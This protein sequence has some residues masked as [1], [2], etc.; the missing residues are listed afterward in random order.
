MQCPRRASHNPSGT[1]QNV[2]ACAYLAAKDS[3]DIVFA[4]RTST[5]CRLISSRY[6]V[7]FLYLEVRLSYV[8]DSTFLDQSVGYGVVVGGS[9]V[10]NYV[11]LC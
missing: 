6:L 8:A 4:F 11:K 2:T 7:P 3:S 1:G 9:S 10:V 5:P